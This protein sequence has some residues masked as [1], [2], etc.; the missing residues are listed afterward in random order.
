MT[1]EELKQEAEKQGF[2]L[3]RKPDYD[4]SCHRMYPNEM[5]RNKNGTWKCVDRYR[6]CKHQRKYMNTLDYPKTFCRRIDREHR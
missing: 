6:P 5:H 3:V 2:S 4:C 1:V